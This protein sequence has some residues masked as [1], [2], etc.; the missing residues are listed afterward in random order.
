MV[1]SAL[2]SAW[3]WWIKEL[4]DAADDFLATD[5]TTVAN[6]MIVTPE[7]EG[8]RLRRPLRG[9]R[10]AERWLDS[11][12]REGEVLPSVSAI[13]TVPPEEVLTQSF[14]FPLAARREI[15]TAVRLKLDRAS[16]APVEQIYVAIAPPIQAS[17]RLDVRTLLI[18]RERVDSWI[19][20]LTDSN[21][22]VTQ[23]LSE[24]GHPFYAPDAPAKQ[25]R[26]RLRRVVQPA[27]AIGIIFAVVL[28]VFQWQTRTDREAAWLSQAL[29]S[30]K[31]A[32]GE[33]SSARTEWTHRVEILRTIQGE[34]SK[35]SPLDLLTMLHEHLPKDMW[36]QAFHFDGQGA[37]VTIYVPSRADVGALLLDMPG[38][39][40]IT[41]NERVPLGI[42]I[43][44]ERVELR[45]GLKPT[46]RS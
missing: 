10:I 38:I 2:G 30:V 19:R 22:T 9:G 36:I 45:L 32:A 12:P 40:S 20:K 34:V 14:E 15:R 37:T 7:G 6:R 11:Q 18:R 42:G 21:V 13:L 16:P 23:T 39:Q 8:F 3:R 31:K 44:T 26:D 35:P 28:G 1:G 4:S 33:E 24:D 17:G 25:F 43:G 41:E 29:Q 27:L 5:G 46:S